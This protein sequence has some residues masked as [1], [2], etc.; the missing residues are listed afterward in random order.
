[1]KTADPDA[2]ARQ[3]L[4]LEAFDQA[5]RT[6]DGL[7]QDVLSGATCPLQVLDFVGFAL[8]DLLETLPDDDPARESVARTLG[9]IPKTPARN[10]AAAA[11]TLANGTQRWSW[12]PMIEP[13][14][15]A[16]AQEPAA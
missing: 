1:M 9:L 3:A 15:E 8:H 13:A 7:A 4:A 2:L 6:F 10:V 16:L 11:A 12:A 14:I 5:R